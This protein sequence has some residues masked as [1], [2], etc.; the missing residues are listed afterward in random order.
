M[1]SL[2][3]RV[4]RMGHTFA[5]KIALDATPL[6]GRFGGIENALWQTLVALHALDLPCEFHVFVPLDA[7]E[8]PFWKANWMWRRLPFGGERK[9]RR[10]G[11]QQLELPR[12]LARE[13]FD[14]LHATNYVM[15]L[16]CPV[17][18]VVSVPDLIALDHPRFALRANRWHYRAL[19]PQTLKRADILLASTPRGRDAIIRRA[20]GAQVL[21]A[22]LGVESQ[23]FAP[24]SPAELEAVRHK[25]ELPARFLLYAGN[26][27]PKKNLSRLL[28]AVRLLGE[29]A[30]EL[31]FVGA[32]KAWPELEGLKLRTRFLGFI[33]RDDLRALM[34]A[35]AAF[36][37]PSLTEGFGLPVVEALACGARVVASS[38]V[39]I[40]GLNR[41]ARVPDPRDVRSIARAI[42][43]AL[44]DDSFDEQ[45]A[46]EFAARFNWEHTARVWARSYT[47]SE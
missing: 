29:E 41:V 25:F 46:R 3:L 7:P 13:G 18:T 39:P 31:V 43:A 47:F 1:H 4:H 37:F 24:L 28:Q 42:R 5:V 23:W 15:P 10:I 40:P 30:P 16:L 19:L 17:R 26:F 14:L 32:I 45:N 35:C 12:L 36:C 38:A 9:T 2:T 44:C 11:W 33:P 34:S 6:C 22:P 8:S 27:E 21:V 20:P